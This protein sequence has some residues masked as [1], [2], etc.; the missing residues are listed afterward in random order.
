MAMACG[1]MERLA[2]IAEIGCHTGVRNPFM[3]P[4]KILSRIS[5]LQQNPHAICHAEES[6]MLPIADNHCAFPP[7]TF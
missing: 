4:F 2:R 1:G 3:F 7:S 5:V 6:N